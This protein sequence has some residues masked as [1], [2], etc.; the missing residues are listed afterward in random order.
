MTAWRQAWMAWAAVLGLLMMSALLATPSTSAANTTE[1]T[2]VWGL[3]LDEK[4]R[5]LDGASVVLV[6]VH[7][8]AEQRTA[9]ASAGRFEFKDVAPGHYRVEVSAPGYRENA[10]R[11][12]FVPRGERTFIG[13]IV[14]DSAFEIP[15]PYLLQGF[16]TDEV[17][18]G[19]NGVAITVRN[20]VEGYTLT[21]TTETKLIQNV[22][23]RGY[24]TLKVHAGN[25]TLWAAKDGYATNMSSIMINGSMWFNL[26][27]LD[28]DTGLTIYGRAYDASKPTES[29]EPVDVPVKAYAYDV[30]NDRLLGGEF[31][32]FS[33]V[34][35]VYPGEFIVYVDA[36][37]YRPWMSDGPVSVVDESRALGKIRLA[38]IAEEF[39]N[40]TVTFDEDWNSSA[41]VE[42][43]TMNADSDFPAIGEG[44]GDLRMALD[45]EGDHDGVLDQAELDRFMVMIDDMGAYWPDTKSYLRLDGT[46]EEITDACYNITDFEVEVDGLATGPVYRDPEEPPFPPIV[47]RRTMTFGDP[48]AVLNDTGYTVHF[49]PLRENERLSVTFPKGW[50]ALN[51]SSTDGYEIEVTK[52]VDVISTAEIT[53]TCSFSVK[54]STRP[55]PSI[56]VKLED[57]GLP[58]QV[59]DTDNEYVIPVIK[60]EGNDLWTGNITLSASGATDDVGTIENYTWEIGVPGVK[61]YGKEVTYNYTRSGRMHV[62]LSLLDSAGETNTTE[63]VL[64][65]DDVKPTVV[66]FAAKSNTTIDQREWVIFNA[67]GSSDDIPGVVLEYEWFFYREEEGEDEPQPESYTGEEVNFTFAE[68]GTWYVVLNVTDQAGNTATR[69]STELSPPLTIQVLDIDPPVAYAG[70]DVDIQLGEGLE[71]NGSGSTDNDQISIY[72]WD[73]DSDNGLWWTN[74]SEPLATEGAVGALSR[75]PNGTYTK[76]GTYNVTLN[77][78]DPAGLT[79]EDL[80]VVTVK[81]PVIE[82]GAIKVNKQSLQVGNELKVTV[83]LNNSGTV[84]AKSVRVVFYLD[85]E[86]AADKQIDEIKAGKSR[87]VT[88]TWKASEKYEG[89]KGLVGKIKV[90][91]ES[92]ASIQVEQ[93]L[94]KTINVEKKPMPTWVYA[95]GVIVIVAIIGF[96]VYRNR[97]M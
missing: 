41:V 30:V 80:F 5:G 75:I 92:D 20:D 90:T 27:L 28:A 45:F 49:G 71:L 7:T 4:D 9:N 57:G 95:V 70:K 64:H 1:E 48:T 10:S 72:R 33:F 58:Y 94:P 84:D 54:K 68:A 51:G 29:M 82:F 87:E 74:R 19:V 79:D 16:V 63:V 77:V 47:I 32:G 14:L 3:V 17:Q 91:S 83:T 21:T 59:P 39:I 55:V 24:F 26:T 40:V 81:G 15:A 13:E 35:Q 36:P 56:E 22:S 44:F 89:K 42:E 69:N 11:I 93:T 66:T 88:L 25:F 34:I 37:G 85:D 31:S 38:P 96:L 97:K 76:S 12:V 62:K 18:T 23:R 2:T 65:L 61:L 52:V 67:S 53:G 8:G 43:W 73:F 78:S 46:E 60:G 86:R 50:E 6:D